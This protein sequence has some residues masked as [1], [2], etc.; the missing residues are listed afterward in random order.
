MINDFVFV[1]DL[2]CFALY[3]VAFRV[4][5]P[6]S[7]NIGKMQHKVHEKGACV[8]AQLSYV[9][10]TTTKKKWF[11]EFGKQHRTRKVEEEEE[12]DEKSSRMK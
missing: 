7:M 6:M 3:C 4:C 11:K 1:F 2:L 9:Q 5:S 12:K 10:S 8:R